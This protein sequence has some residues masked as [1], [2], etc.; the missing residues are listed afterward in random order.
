MNKKELEKLVDKK[1][2]DPNIEGLGWPVVGNFKTILYLSLGIMVSLALIGIFNK[3][4]FLQAVESEKEAR[5]FKSSVS[6]LKKENERLI[7]EIDSLKN[8]PRHM[9]KIAREDLGLALPDETIFVFP[10]S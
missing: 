7:R 4:G 1:V 3:D 5:A 8:D 10:D 2:I 9:E 6:K